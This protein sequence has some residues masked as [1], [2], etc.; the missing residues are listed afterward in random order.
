MV[1][2]IGA[3]IGMLLP[4]IQTVRRVGRR[5]N[6]AQHLAQLMVAVH[7][8]EGAFQRYPPGTLNNMG[9]VLSQPVGY[10]HS[11]IS[12][13][14]PYLEQ[15]TAYHRIDR[16]V[17]VYHANNASVRRV[18]IPNLR[19]PSSPAV[20]RGYSDY[21]GV[22]HDQEAPI[23][24]S[25]NG[26]FFLNSAIRYQDV[27]DGTSNTCFIGEKH[28]LVGDLGWMSGTRSTL[29][30]MVNP[31]ITRAATTLPFARSRPPDVPQPNPPPPLEGAELLESLF[32]EA[33][34]VRLL[35][36]AGRAL[37]PFVR[38]KNPLL[39]VGGF[40]GMHLGGTQFALGDGSVR[41]LSGATDAWHYKYLGNRA[42]R[43]LIDE[44]L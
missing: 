17:G 42:D 20:G 11:W 28:T 22:H 23:D 26:V 44:G 33:V 30:N 24:V 25:N 1:A 8:Y 7:Q 37:P 35:G 4:A 32:G 21:A 29:R 16:S 13:I 3:L 31:Q 2:V 5:H 10:H 6:C 38:P 27:L 18:S 12:Q 34:D 19:C 14:L 15:T 43:Q 36:R 41:F 40:S 39:A 9:P